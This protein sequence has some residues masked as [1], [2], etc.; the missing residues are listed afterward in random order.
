VCLQKLKQVLCQNGVSDDKTSIGR[1][2]VRAA[3]VIYEHFEIEQP[4]G[5][6]PP[7]RPTLDRDREHPP[8]VRAAK[9][10]S[11]PGATRVADFSD[12]VRAENLNCSRERR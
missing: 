9:G 2:V 5:R 4:C 8:A 12:H 1:K 3:A 10:N 11:R 7:R 6:R